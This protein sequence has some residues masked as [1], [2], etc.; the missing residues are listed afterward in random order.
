M[1]Y[2][3]TFENN[4]CNPKTLEVYNK[5]INSPH[6]FSWSMINRDDVEFEEVCICFQHYNESFVVFFN[7]ESEIGEVFIDLP[8]ELHE[9]FGESEYYGLVEVDRLVDLFKS[10]PHL[11]GVLVQNEGGVT[12]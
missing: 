4:C 10:M 6:C 12:H 7:V 11:N 1:Q 9:E 2:Q 8:R 5:F 3:T